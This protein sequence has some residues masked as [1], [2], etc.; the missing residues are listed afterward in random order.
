[1]VGVD[2]QRDGRET[3]GSHVSAASL[4]TFVETEVFDLSKNVS[5]IEVSKI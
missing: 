1:M 2:T 5:R 3:W 4:F